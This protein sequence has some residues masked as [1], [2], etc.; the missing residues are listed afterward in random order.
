MAKIGKLS[1]NCSR[2][3]L[4]TA[5]PS[6]SVDFSSII[7][8]LHGR[9]SKVVSISL[10]LNPAASSSASDTSPV[11]FA[12]VVPSSFCTITVLALA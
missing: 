12:V 9:S 10:L 6:N 8:A 11:L 2:S 3:F 1:P 5:T 4:I 7:K